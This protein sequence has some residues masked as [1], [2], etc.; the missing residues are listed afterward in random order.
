MIDPEEQ[1]I[2]EH[3]EHWQDIIWPMCDRPNQTLSADHYENL[4]WECPDVD[5][6]AQL[7]RAYRYM[8]DQWSEPGPGHRVVS[9]INKW[10]RTNQHNVDEADRYFPREGRR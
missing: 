9:F 3:P 2:P 4:C 10:M 6:A 7:L 5:V 1:D 8:L